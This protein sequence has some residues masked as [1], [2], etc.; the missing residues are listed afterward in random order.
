MNKAMYITAIAM[1]ATVAMIGCID[2]D[3]PNT[4]KTD[5]DMSNMSVRIDMIEKYLDDRN[6]EADELRVIT[7]R[8]RVLVDELDIWTDISNNW[9]EQEDQLNAE[10]DQFYYGG[11]LE[12]QAYADWYYV[13]YEPFVDDYMEFLDDHIVFLKDY[14]IKRD[15]VIADRDAHTVK[16]DKHWNNTEYW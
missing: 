6:T 1:I 10:Y 13:E 11:R 14:N 4:S 16:W 8:S 3:S 2:S 12:T 5:Q 9:I 15:I 7:D